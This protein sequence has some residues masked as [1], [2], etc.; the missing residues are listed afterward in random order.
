MMDAHLTES[1]AST[2]SAKADLITTK[3]QSFSVRRLRSPHFFILTTLSKANKTPFEEKAKKFAFAL[4]FAVNCNVIMVLK[5][6]DD[7]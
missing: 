6:G 3:L 1:A 2:S 4:D 7:L 5:R